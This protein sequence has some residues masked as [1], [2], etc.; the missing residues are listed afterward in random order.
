MYVIRRSKIS[1]L[2]VFL[3]LAKMVHFINLPAEKDIIHEKITRSRKSFRAVADHQDPHADRPDRSAVGDS[4]LF[5]FSIEDTAT[6]NP[7]GTSMVVSSMGGPGNPNISFALERKEF[8]STDLQQGTSHTVATLYLDESSP[9]EIGGLILGPSSRRHPMKLGKQ[10][11]LV[12]FHF[13][14]LYREHFADRILAEM[15][16][17]VSSEGDNTFWDHLGRRFINMPYDEADRFCQH[18][19][20][21]MLSLLP[22]EPVYLTLL[23]PQARQ[24]VAQVGAD[25]VPARRML[26]ELGFRYTGRIDPF[27]GGPHLEAHTD[28]IDLIRRT[29]HAAYAGSCT[30]LETT[31][32]G[33]VSFLDDEGEFRCVYTAFRLDERGGSIV[34]PEA[35]AQA[36]DVRDG[37][38]LGY[39]PLDLGIAGI[40]AGQPAVETMS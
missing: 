28:E 14:G 37:A 22:R 30:E 7:L 19:R 17:P 32:T 39:T 25:T 35:S 36:L 26:E 12:R 23:T 33:F 34:L 3:K 20:E 4:A 27:D 5:M 2:D 1:D 9:S 29:T 38:R 16:A 13:M 31:A 8:F 18:S 11:G 24:G 6:G 10:L 40:Q 21:F 15:M